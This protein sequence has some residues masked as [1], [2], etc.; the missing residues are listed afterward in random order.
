MDSC[1]L[2][3]ILSPETNNIYGP[4]SYRLFFQCPLDVCVFERPTICFILC[5]PIL[6]LQ[7][8]LNLFFLSH[9]NL[10]ILSRPGSFECLFL[11][12]CKCHLPFRNSHCLRTVWLTDSWFVTAGGGDFCTSLMLFLYRLHVFLPAIVCWVVYKRHSSSNWWCSSSTISPTD[13]NSSWPGS[14]P[15]LRFSP[16]CYVHSPDIQV[17][18]ILL[19]C[20]YLYSLN[21][22]CN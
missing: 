22:L 15:R 10:Y 13:T 19:P 18:I 12:L 14:F 2:S 9:V 7:C 21:I 17:R 4:W 8:V 3:H 5:W 6:Y 1:Y 11:S 20:R 16:A